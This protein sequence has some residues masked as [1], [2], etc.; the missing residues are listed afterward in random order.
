MPEQMLK[1]IRIA[2][3]KSIR[4]ASLDLGPVTVLIG[5]NGSGK[6]N[7][8]AFFRMLG[9]LAADEFQVHV[10]QCGGANALLHFGAKQ[11]PEIET[12]LVFQT[13]SGEGR[14]QLR[15]AA[16]ADDRLV[17]LEE[18]IA[19]RRHPESPW[20]DV[21]GRRGGHKE[22]ALAR[23]ATPGLGLGETAAAIRQVLDR[24]R[25]FHFHD[26]SDT[27]AMRRGCRVDENRHLYPDGSNVAAMLYA[28]RETRPVAYRRIV[29]TVRQV[30][31]FLGDFVLEP[32]RLNPNSI[33]LKWRQPGSDYEFAPHQLSDGSLRMI[34]LATLLLQPEEDL[35]PLVV[36]DEPELG[37]HPAAINLLASLVRKAS[38]HCQIVLATQSPALVDCFDPADVVVATGTEGV[39][40]FERLDPQALKEWLEDYSLSELW[41]KNVIGGGDPIDDSAVLL[42]GRPDRAGLCEAGAERP[43]CPLRGHGRGRFESRPGGSTGWLIAAADGI[44][45]R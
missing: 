5:A 28:Y 36:I 33:S 35:P 3:W 26:T 23:Y 7:L 29:S 1:H 12:E 42:R 37:L 11:T 14:Y 21:D 22:A 8:V 9:R 43:L 20:L 27:S 6:S 45:R 16:A 39:T 34:A 32:D 41:E 10:A 44:T 30:T 17:V 31:P 19:S 24:C 15:F 4:D 38:H 2:G 13:P 25:V 40:T 18:R